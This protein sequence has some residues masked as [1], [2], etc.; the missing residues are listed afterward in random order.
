MKGSKQ[1]NVHEAKTH[2]SKLLAEVEKGHEIVLARDGRPIAKIVPFPA[3]KNRITFNDLKGEIW[4]KDDFDELS[5][6]LLEEWGLTQRRPS[7]R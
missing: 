1:V 2:L 6:E 5:D 3:K 4:M 7:P